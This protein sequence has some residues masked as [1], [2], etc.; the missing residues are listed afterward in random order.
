MW[1]SVGPRSASC[2]YI[3]IFMQLK[4]INDVYCDMFSVEYEE[5]RINSSFTEKQKNQLHYSLCAIIVGYAFS[6]S[7]CAFT[8]N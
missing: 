1:A 4:D 6:I 8:F 5:C 3:Q 2:E 7:I